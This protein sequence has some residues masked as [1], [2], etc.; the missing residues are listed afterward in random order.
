[1]ESLSLHE[2]IYGFLHPETARCYAALALIYRQLGDNETA[3]D[4]QRRAVIVAERV[5]GIDHADTI[6][7]YMNLGLFEHALGRTQLALRYLRRAMDCWRVVYG[8]HHPD[9][10]TTDVSAI[11][12][13]SILAINL[14]L[15]ILILLLE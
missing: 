2:Q 13:I 10:A 5:I 3:E 7:Y 6:N 8:D 15:M 9:S 14:R 4:F 11:V 12:F 1:M